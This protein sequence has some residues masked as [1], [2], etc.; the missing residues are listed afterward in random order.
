MSDDNVIHAFGKADEL[1]ENLLQVRRDPTMYCAHASIL[2]DEHDRS[3]QCCK[4]GATLDAFDFLRLNGLHIQMAWQNYRQAKSHVEALNESVSK[5]Q[6]EEKRLKALV[7][8]L[9]DK[10]GAKLDVRGPL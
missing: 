5:L 8:R 1:P 6:R 3:V 7:K 10:T 2:L 9:Q 4:C